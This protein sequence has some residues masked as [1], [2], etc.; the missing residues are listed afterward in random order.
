MSTTIQTLNAFCRKYDL[1][2]VET[3]RMNGTDVYW[4]LDFN[5]ERRYY[6]FAE[7]ESKL[8]VLV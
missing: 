3:G 5:N 8:G 7:I 4:F 6:S 2:F 1:V